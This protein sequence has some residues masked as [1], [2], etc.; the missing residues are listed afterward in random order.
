MFRPRSII[1]L[2]WYSLKWALKVCFS[3]LV[4]YSTAIQSFVSNPWCF[5]MRIFTF[6]LCNKKSL[7][8]IL[9]EEFVFLSFK[10]LLPL[11]LFLHPLLPLPSQMQTHIYTQV[12]QKKKVNSS[13]IYPI[14]WLVKTKLLHICTYMYLQ[15]ASLCLPFTYLHAL[16]F[17]F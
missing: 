7:V 4:S 10:L 3:W 16:A 14:I 8:R 6:N 9:D 5:H 2:C 13:H 12:V 1:G 17:Q 11:F 15:K